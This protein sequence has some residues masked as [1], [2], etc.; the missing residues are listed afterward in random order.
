MYKFLCMVKQLWFTEN[1]PRKI[2]VESVERIEPAR[3]EE[4]SEAIADVVAELSAATATLGA[5]LHPLTA[6]NLAGL[7]RIMNSDYSNLIEGHVRAAE[8]YCRALEGEFD[9]DH[10]RRNLQI[11]AASHVRVQADIDQLA[12]ENKL[13]E[14]ASSD[15][16]RRL[17]RDFYSDAPKDMLIIRSANHEFTMEPGAWRSQPEHDVAVGRHIPPSSSR[18]EAF[19]QYFENRYRFQGLGKAARVLAIPAAHHRLNYIHPFPDGNGRV[20][21]LMS[22]A[23]RKLPASERTGFGPF[24]AGWRV[25]SRAVANT[26]K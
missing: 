7:V 6:A 11:E 26:S 25:A 4:A 19:M 8:R 24:R 23:M 14:P 17:H 10:E 16:I 21:R 12:L 5:S 3:L 9:K 2:L 15:F 1:R 13:P 20:S 22:H 18:V